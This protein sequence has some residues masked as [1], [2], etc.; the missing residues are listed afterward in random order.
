MRVVRHESFTLP[1]SR[2]LDPRGHPGR[3][4]AQSLARELFVWH[5]QHFDVDINPVE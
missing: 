1:F 3:W 4:L 2:C 5:A